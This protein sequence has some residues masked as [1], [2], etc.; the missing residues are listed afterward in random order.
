MEKRN[1]MVSMDEDRDLLIEAFDNSYRLAFGEV[2]I[3]GLKQECVMGDKDLYMIY[4][5]EDGIGEEDLYDM[6]LWYEDL[7]EY[8]RC[9]VIKR[10]M[11]ENFGRNDV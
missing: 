9:G 5:Y 8:E 2:S 7:E 10:Y 6:L 1:I 11:D 4:H 3:E